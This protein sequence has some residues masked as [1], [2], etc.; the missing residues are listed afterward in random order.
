MICPH[1]D[2]CG[3]CQTKEDYPIALEQKTKVFKDIFC[4]SPNKV[5]ESKIR[6]FR[7]RAE[8][9]I[10][11][12]GEKIFLSMNTLGKNE[13]VA[14]QNCPNLLEHLQHILYQLPNLL[15][16]EILKHK[17]YAINVLG[18]T[19]QHAIIT[20]I[21]HKKLDL[22]WQEEA[23]LLAKHLNASIIG[24]SKNQ[25][26]ILGTNLIE[27]HIKTKN[28]ILRYFYKEGSF[29]QPN[30]FINEKMINFIIDN[31]QSHHRKDLLEMYC[32]SGNFTIALAQYFTK[33][34]ATEV[35]KSAIPI[36]Q[37]N[38]QNNQIK[39]LYYARLS[40]I[41]TIE[42]LSFSR[43]FFRLK[44][45]NLSTFNF[46]HILV[47]PPRSGI[48]DIKILKFMANFEYII[49]ISCNP[50]TLKEDST[51]L[52]KTH[53]ITK[54]AIFDQFPHTHHLESIFIFQKNS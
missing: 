36:L 49:Y 9:R 17:L 41:E 10:H 15:N 48:A 3:G 35:V 5:F 37:Q 20:L 29:S 51:H 30:P 42:A 21:Y 46:S 43:K 40:G 31:I 16:Q 1:F 45:I 2:I 44:D 19:N 6:G 4:F 32:G 11:R 34:F 12:D 50:L 7:A 14:I 13:R 38:A 39:N 53:K 22:L 52:L 47:D 27:S 23:L 33:V 18:S 28:K 54:S 24:R 25:E 8:F 26:I